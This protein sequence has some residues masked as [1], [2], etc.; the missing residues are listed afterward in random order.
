MQLRNRRLSLN[1]SQSRV[2]RISGVSRFKLNQFELG[3]KALSEAELARVNR[4][5]SQEAKRLRR[6]TL[7]THRETHD[8]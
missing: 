8:D 3:G 2:S 7:E 4:A 1:L 5:I 6:K